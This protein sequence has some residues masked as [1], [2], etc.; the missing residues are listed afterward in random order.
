MAVQVQ[1]PIAVTTGAYT[2]ISSAAFARY[3]EIA[4]DGTVAPA[5]LRVKWPN[6]NVDTYTPAQQPI[7]IGTPEGRAFVGVP[8]YTTGVIATL[9]CQI[10]S[11]AATGS[12]R[13]S[14][15]N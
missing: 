6:G 8:S 10:E 9:Y 1:A 4:E 15:Y 7:K 11:V 3:V 2:N 13:V 14:E 5:G 12:V